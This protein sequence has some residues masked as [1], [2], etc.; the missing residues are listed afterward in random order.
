MKEELEQATNELRIARRVKLNHI[1]QNEMI[2]Y[3]L[4]MLFVI[5]VCVYVCVC[6]LFLCMYQ[7]HRESARADFVEIFVDLLLFLLS[8]LGCKLFSVTSLE[9]SL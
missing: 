1:L 5:F 6:V 2:A 3:V 7:S 8:I 4:C 9:S